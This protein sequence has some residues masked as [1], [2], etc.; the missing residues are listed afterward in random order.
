MHVQ[1]RILTNDINNTI[2]NSRRVNG[3][4]NYDIFVLLIICN[5]YITMSLIDDGIR[6]RTD[7]YRRYKIY[8]VYSLTKKTLQTN[9][10][11]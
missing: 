8:M 6:H 1:D 9:F 5:V 4:Q 2:N 7:K 11:D 3:H 10:E